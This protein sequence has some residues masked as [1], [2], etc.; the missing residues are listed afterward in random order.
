MPNNF[1]KVN[2]IFKDKLRVPSTWLHLHGSALHG[3]RVDVNRPTSGD[4]R[5]RDFSSVIPYLTPR[6]EPQNQNQ[7]V[8]QHVQ[9][10][11]QRDVPEESGDVVVGEILDTLRWLRR[12]WWRWSWSCCR[13]FIVKV[14]MVM[15]V[16][17]DVLWKMIMRI[18][19]MEVEIYGRI[20][21]HFERGH[22]CR[23]HTHR[24]HVVW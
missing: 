21:S 11:V 22:S 12:W 17:E 1:I 14:I 6:Y 9:A 13:W 19:P 8:E 15:I 2:T 3:H 18:I 20:A 4:N 7:H 24:H 23:G 10:E 16:I 5:I